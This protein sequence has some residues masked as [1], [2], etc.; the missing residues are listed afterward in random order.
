[1]IKVPIV[2][3]NTLNV[4]FTLGGLL[5]GFYDIPDDVVDPMGGDRQPPAFVS[6]RIVDAAEPREALGV[7]RVPRPITGRVNAVAG[8]HVNWISRVAKMVYPCVFSILM[9]R[10]ARGKRETKPVCW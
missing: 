2:T 3:V 7:H 8:A 1:M 9:G 10:G 4:R 5:V 6:Y